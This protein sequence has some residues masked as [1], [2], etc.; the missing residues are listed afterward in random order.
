MNERMNIE[1]PTPVR[2]SFNEGGFNAQHRMMNIKTK[3]EHH[4]TYR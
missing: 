4:E 2:R 3:G 1:R